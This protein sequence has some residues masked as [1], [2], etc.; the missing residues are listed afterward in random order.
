MK[1]AF[2]RYLRSPVDVMEFSMFVYAAYKSHSSL[3]RNV[4]KTTFI[5]WFCSKVLRL[6]NEYSGLEQILYL[7]DEW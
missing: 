6:L 2:T 1:F 7:V 4:Y 3:F 5:L